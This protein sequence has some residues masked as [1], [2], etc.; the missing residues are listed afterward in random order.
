MVAPSPEQLPQLASPASASPSQAKAPPPPLVDPALAKEA[1]R[2]FLRI[3]RATKAG[4]FP[5]PLNK[6]RRGC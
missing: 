4:D 2:E 3:L 1:D 5:A 6:V